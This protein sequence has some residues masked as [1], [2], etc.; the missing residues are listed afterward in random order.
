MRKTSLCIS[1]HTAEE[2]GTCRERRGFDFDIYNKKKKRDRGEKRGCVL[3]FSSFFG[4]CIIGKE[5]WTFLSFV[6]IYTE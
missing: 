1:N 3:L 4:G 6:C 5:S 2:R